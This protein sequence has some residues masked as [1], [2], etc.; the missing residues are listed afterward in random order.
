MERDGPGKIDGLISLAQPRPGTARRQNEYIESPLN[1]PPL[2]KLG[3]GKAPVTAQ[4]KKAPASSTQEDPGSNPDDHNDSIICRQC[5]RC[6]CAACRRGR[7][8][9]SRWICNNKCL[10][11][12]HTAVDYCSCM[13]CVRGLFYHWAKDY[14]M[15]S[16]VSCADQPCSCAPHH[17]LLRW[18]CLGLLSLPLPCL[19][20]Y[21]PLKGCVKACEGCYA[22]CTGHGCRCEAGTRP[23]EKRLL[24]SDQG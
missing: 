2:P 5:R 7:A 18:G 22:R 24:D 19:C 4:P 12:P 9:P 17:R 6:R 14:E 10:C 1:R 8:L 13:C 23:P 16:D 21:W 11:S 20:C 3:A 15:D